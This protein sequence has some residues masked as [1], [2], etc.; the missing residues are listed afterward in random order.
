MFMKTCKRIIRLN[1]TLNHHVWL[2]YA[3]HLSLLE[4]MANLKR[5][6]IKMSIY[7]DEPRASSFSRVQKSTI[8]RNKVAY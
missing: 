7:R 1:K 6:G 8:A 2:N 4:K 5:T 3:Q